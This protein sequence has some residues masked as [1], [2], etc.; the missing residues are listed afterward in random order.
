MNDKV[1][2]YCTQEIAPKTSRKTKQN[3]KTSFKK[4]VLIYNFLKLFSEEEFV[5]VWNVSSYKEK[6][7]Q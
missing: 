4:M 7:T 3:K 2:D 5:L 1:T 6:K